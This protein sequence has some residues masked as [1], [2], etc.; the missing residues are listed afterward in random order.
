MDTYSTDWLLPRYGMF[1]LDYADRWPELTTALR[2]IYLEKTAGIPWLPRNW[3]ASIDALHGSSGKLLMPVR[4]FATASNGE[5]PKFLNTPEKRAWWD[6]FQ[7]QVQ[8]AHQA[9]LDGERSKGLALMNAAYANT[10]FWTAA[11]NI[12]TVLA[13]PVTAVSGV[14]GFMAKYPQAAQMALVGGVLLAAWYFFRRKN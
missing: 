7:E 10:R 8:A 14:V 12:A 5:T 13:T 6:D 3:R 4:S 9:F 1:A 11:H 2:R